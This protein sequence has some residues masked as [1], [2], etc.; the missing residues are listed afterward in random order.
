MDDGREGP[1]AQVGHDDARNLPEAA[2]A[3]DGEVGGQVLLPAL[4]IGNLCKR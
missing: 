4:A 3:I 2:P 1:D